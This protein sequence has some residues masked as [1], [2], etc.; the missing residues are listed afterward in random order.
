MNAETGPSVE[1]LLLQAIGILPLAG[2]S[3]LLSRSIQRDSLRYFWRAWT[4]LAIALFSLYFSLRL[5]VL[6]PVLE[7]L[8]YLGEY[9]F[10]GFVLAGCRVLATGAR[11]SRRSRWLLLVAAPLAPE[12]K[13]FYSHPG[14][15]PVAMITLSASISVVLSSA[16]VMRSR[17]LVLNDPVP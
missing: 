7:P 8:Y 5:P 16:P 14:F 6:R 12:D 1:A 10:A 9:V 13:E 4:S 2:L 15:D 3:F 11:A 17:F